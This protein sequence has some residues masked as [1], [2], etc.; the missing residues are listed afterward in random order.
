MEVAFSIE[1]YFQRWWKIK[2]AEL[3][4]LPLKGKK[5]HTTIGVLKTEIPLLNTEKLL[6]GFKPVP[7]KW[8][9]CSFLCAIELLLEA[10]QL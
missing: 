7:L 1:V 6:P 5:K 2:H 9:L 8:A 3:G 4:N 10:E